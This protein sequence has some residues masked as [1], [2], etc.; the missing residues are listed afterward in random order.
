MNLLRHLT[1][2]IRR[3]RMDDELRDELDQHVR[4]KTQQLED[5]GVPREEARRQAAIAVG[6]VSRLRE[7]A[8]AVWGFP[9]L[10][11]LAQDV[12]YGLR[13]ISRAPGFSA[14]AILSLGIG[15]GATTAVFSLAD[16]ILLRAMA[17]REPARLFVIK[18]RSGP[19]FPFSSLNGWGDQTATETTST[20]FSF[21]TY[22][23]FRSQ[24]SSHI[25]VLGFADLYQVNVV[26]DGRAELATAHAVSGN[27]FEVLGVRAAVGRTLAAADDAVDAPGA[28]VI[29]D[30]LWRRR[31]GGS[32]DAIG[33]T[34]LIN[35]SPFTIAGIAPADFH[36]TGQ[37][38]TDPDL[39]V[40][41]LLHA[42]VMPN[43]DPIMDPNF[44]WVLM[45]GRLKPGAR[46]DETRN[47]LD[48]LLKR[49]VATARPTMAAK[50]LPRADLRPG[51]LGQAEERE[52]LRAP[53]GMMAVVTAVVLLVACANVAGLLLSRG[54]ARV[55]EL[56]VR[57]AI[58]ASRG[59][60]VRQLLTEALLIAG[61]GALAGLAFARWLSATL[62]PA[63]NAGVAQSLT[64]INGSVLAFA[65]LS[66]CG[67][68]VLFGLLPA[69]RAT[70]LDAGPGL[71]E[72]GRD[73]ALGARH[74]MLGGVVVVVQIALALLLVTGAGLLVR[75]LRNLERVDLGFA[76]NNLLL[77]RVDPTL[78]GYEGQR[79]LK[80]YAGLLDRVRATPGVVDAS[81]ASHRLIANSA[82]IGNAARTDEAPPAPGSP[83]ARS[84][85]R[86]HQAWA[87]IVD[88]R[89]FATVQI[90]FVRGRTFEPADEQSGPVAVIN[91]TL[92]RRLFGTEDA[93][94][95]SLRFGSIRR[96]NTP[97]LQVV[98]VVED[99]RYSSV[100][101]DMPPT[102]YMYY[103]QRPD[104][105]DAPTFYVRTAVAPASMT[106]AM[107][108]IVRD[109]DP[110]LPL[111]DVTTQTDQIATS[112][113]RERLF[114]ELAT[115]LGGVALLLSAIGLYGLLAYGVARRTPEI[116]L[117]MALGAQRERV[118]WMILRESLVLA[119]GGVLL[120][121]PVA[122]AGTQVLQSLLFGLASRDLATLTAAALS[123]FVLAAVASYVPA[124]R[125][126]QVDPLVALRAE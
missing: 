36:G 24:A 94:G 87:L 70:H 9:T 88:E 122:L 20:S 18:W 102:V 6:N 106:P 73:P 12:R 119:A 86:S 61:G 37:V 69:F 78:N 5:S 120:G 54:R 22:Q 26:S 89:F 101:A 51:G 57:V 59:R 66:A 63:L 74:R 58:G 72:A 77:F 96:T 125:A 55:R 110:R 98:G 118:Q 17:V 47:T 124:R 80:L 85:Q 100:R 25:D 116:G 90:A 13:Q 104:M 33:K 8:R 42:R 121:V 52:E 39:Y 21:A 91:R 112:L 76:A 32:T 107:R 2:W 23:A 53:L 117:R 31:F 126:A 28:A 93:L 67:S 62:A 79:A 64:A 123:M 10:D 3:S 30:R 46:P 81:I 45:M 15:I 38:G 4:C 103:R 11:S 113:R 60:L 108:E 65:V 115:L 43:D 109:F 111:Y 95:R 105:K 92:A 84:F 50:D 83:E 71:Q 1:A 7:D 16:T 34:I 41:L 40:A 27:Y 35:S 44:W 75:T 48:V 56:S 114:A 97:P 14:V 49:S 68:A 82:T 29:S 99:A 19:V